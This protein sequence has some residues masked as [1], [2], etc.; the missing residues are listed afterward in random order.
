[1]NLVSQLDKLIEDSIRLERNGAEWC[2]HESSPRATHTLLRLR[3]GPA[4]AFSLDIPGKDLFPFF[5][6]GT[7]LAGMRSVCDA[8]AVVQVQDRA[9]IMAI[10]M[11]S[12]SSGEADAKRQLSRA[13]C[14]IEWLIDSLTL[15]GHWYGTWD[16]CGII[17]LKP[18]RQERK[19]AT[20][21]TQLPSPKEHAGFKFFVLEN[22]P[23]LDLLT[24]AHALTLA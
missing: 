9:L 15:N 10:E 18:R 19:G 13:K 3:G 20:S 8:F 23:V 22:H 24:L 21:R 4:L 16:F 12:S 11:K 1:M 7:P 17:S 2:L 14:F 5:K 6:A